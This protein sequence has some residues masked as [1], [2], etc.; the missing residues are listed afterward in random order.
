M[1]NGSPF[2]RPSWLRTV[3]CNGLHPCNSYFEPMS[4][5]HMT[6]PQTSSECEFTGYTQ[7]F[8]WIMHIENVFLG[9]V[10]LISVL[11]LSLSFA[12]QGP[13]SGIIFH[14]IFLFNGNLISDKLISWSSDYDNFLHSI[15]IVSSINFEQPFHQ[16][17]SEIK[18][19]LNQWNE[20]LFVMSW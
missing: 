4:T 3:M 19:N 6:G 8:V 5:Y 15:T 11:P 12:E 9:Q 2:K 10:G 7:K 1:S 14:W 20:P 18:V 16:H 13:I 17:L